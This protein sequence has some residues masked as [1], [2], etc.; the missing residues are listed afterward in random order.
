MC[1]WSAAKKVVGGCLSFAISV[2]QLTLLSAF[3]SKLRPAAH[4]SIEL[5][6]TA[7]T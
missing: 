3:V 2:S 4:A 1:C 5:P 7:S 6:V